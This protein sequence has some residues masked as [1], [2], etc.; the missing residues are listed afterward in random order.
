MNKCKKCLVTYILH[1]ELI[2]IIFHNAKY[3]IN[4]K[5]FIKTCEND[6]K[7]IILVTKLK[8]SFYIKWLKSHITK[9]LLTSNSVEI[10]IYLPLKRQ[11]TFFE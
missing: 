5:T 9:P 7:S 3:Y 6:L 2:L 8:K 1:I 11:I 4:S 10:K